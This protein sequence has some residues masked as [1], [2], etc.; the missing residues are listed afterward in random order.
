MQEEDR[1]ELPSNTHR[2][3]DRMVRQDAACSEIAEKLLT[4]DLTGNKRILDNDVLMEL[5]PNA[6]LN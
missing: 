4:V 6:S 3:N 1:P 2:S 5:L